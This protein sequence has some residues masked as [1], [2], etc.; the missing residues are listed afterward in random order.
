MADRPSASASGVGRPRTRSAHQTPSVPKFGEPRSKSVYQSKVKDSAKKTPAKQK[1]L[2]CSPPLE[3]DILA[4][5]DPED[6]GYPL[7]ADQLPDLPPID[8]K[9]VPT[10]N[11]QLN[12]PYQPLDLPEVE[13][14][15][16]NLPPNQPNPHNQPQTLLLINQTKQIDLINLKIL[17]LNFQ[18]NL[19]FNLTNH[20]TYQQTH[21]IQWQIHRNYTGL[22]L[23]L[24]FQENQ[25]KMW[26]HIY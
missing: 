10:N 25:K 14:N 7:P 19:T 26:R 16:P 3:Q 17:L 5:I 24:N 9:Q 8:L 21:L 13:L 2:R 11:P 18:I 20:L 6:Q 22:V 4:V 23:N 1:S 12:P 15:Q